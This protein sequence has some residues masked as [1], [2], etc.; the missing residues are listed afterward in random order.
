[1]PP[2]LASQNP[3]PGGKFSPA[4]T[5]PIAAFAISVAFAWN[6]CTAVSTKSSSIAASPSLTTSGEIAISVTCPS[7]CPLTVT[8]PP[9]LPNSTAV[10]FRPC[11]ASCIFFCIALTCFIIFM[12]L[13]ITNFSCFLPPFPGG[14]FPPPP[15]PPPHSPLAPI[16]ILLRPAPSGRFP[17]FPSSLPL[18]LNAR[19]PSP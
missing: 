13:G 8:A 7:A 3:N 9:P 15:P 6:P 4:V 10:S 16:R 1:M 18:P 19:F 2:S 5:A 17:T 14:T 11:C 12:I